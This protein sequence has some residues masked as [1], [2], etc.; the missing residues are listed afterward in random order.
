AEG[1]DCGRYFGLD[2][3]AGVMRMQEAWSVGTADV[4]RFVNDSRQ[5][6]IA[7]GAGLVGTVWQSGEALWVPDTQNDPRALLA[8]KGWSRGSFLSP[9]LSDGRIVG[10]L[11]LTSSNASEPDERLVQAM[12]DLARQIGEIVRRK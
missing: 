12:C 10:V 6:A 1:W 7:P 2:S 3:D 8:P 4:E 9:V 5:L 11:A